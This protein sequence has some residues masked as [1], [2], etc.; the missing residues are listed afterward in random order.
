MVKRSDIPEI[1]DLYAP[2]VL[3]TPVS[4]EIEVPS[5]CEFISR[6]EKISQQ[7][8]YLVCTVDDTVLG[9]AYASQHATRAAYRYDVQVSVYVQP[10]Y[11]G[12]G[13]AGLLYQALFELLREQG[14]INAYAGIT[15]PN[16]R[17]VGFHKKQ[18]FSEVGV[19]HQTG[20]KFQKWYDVLWLEKR[21][22]DL[23]DEPNWQPGSL[24]SIGSI[25]PFILERVLQSANEMFKIKTISF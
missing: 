6:V 23:P 24:L 1:L 13:C 20:Y 10:E 21:L 12:T 17:S 25:S 9:Y 22:I 3:D 7:Y 5:I 2:F 14:Y 18:G 16:E 11:H 8:P 15:L 19:Y 4:F